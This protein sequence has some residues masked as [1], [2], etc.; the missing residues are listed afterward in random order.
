MSKDAAQDKSI[1]IGELGAESSGAARAHARDL[2][3]EYGRFVLAQPGAARFC[4]G[5]LEEEAARLPHSYLEQHG[6]L[7]LAYVNRAPA[8]CVAWRSLAASQVVVPHACEMKRLWVRPSARGLGLGRRLAE[9]V[10]ARAARDG[11]KAMYLNTA[12]A[13]MGAAHRMYLDLGFVPCPAYNDNPVEDLAYLVK[14]L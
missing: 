9:A 10:L 6:G 1:H 8:G 5:S 11:C 2:F 4:F 13:S 7:L 14:F 12:P 3:L